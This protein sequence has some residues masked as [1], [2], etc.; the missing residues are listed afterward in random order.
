M[1]N[2]EKIEKKVTGVRLDPE[3]VKRLKYLG[4]DLDRSLTSLLE[5]AARDLL[6]KYE[7]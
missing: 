2:R 7:K 4:V 6:K 5:E 1:V 3:L